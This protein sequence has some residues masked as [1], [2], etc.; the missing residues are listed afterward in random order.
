M[1]EERRKGKSKRKE[2]RERKRGREKKKAKERKRKEKGRKNER[3]EGITLY[4]S[5]ARLFCPVDFLL[6][7]ML[8]VLWEFL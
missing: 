8:I 4:I 7:T 2:K 1:C 6:R 5:Y 3:K